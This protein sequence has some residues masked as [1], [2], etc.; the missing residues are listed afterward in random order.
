MSKS[1]FADVGARASSGA[2]QGTA[3]SWPGRSEHLRLRHEVDVGV[4]HSSDVGGL[5]GSLGAFEQPTGIVRSCKRTCSGGYSMVGEGTDRRCR[6]GPGRHHR[7]RGACGRADGRRSAHHRS[8][9]PAYDPSAPAA[10]RGRQSPC[11]DRIFTEV[12][13]DM[14]R[15]C[16]ANRLEGAAAID[17]AQH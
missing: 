2:R 11:E 9:S 15:A 7:C 6:F 13:A 3:T 1:D 17:L 8:R 12:L 16:D 5:G 10:A 14:V 4:R